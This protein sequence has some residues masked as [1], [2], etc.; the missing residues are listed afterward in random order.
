MARA[1]WC[2]AQTVR[3]LCARTSCFHSGSCSQPQI[4]ELRGEGVVTQ[5]TATRQKT[6]LA[7]IPLRQC[8]FLRTR[9]V[10]MRKGSEGASKST[11]CSSLEF[12]LVVS[13]GGDM[14]EERGSC[15]AL[16]PRE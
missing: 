6:G 7:C 15:G 3:I 10:S 8:H 13:V 2:L 1:T 12:C 5:T 11:V 16:R 9:A 4:K 14:V